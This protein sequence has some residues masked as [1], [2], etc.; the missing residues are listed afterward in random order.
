MS[1]RCAQRRFTGRGAAV[2]A[3]GAD[4][5]VDCDVVES[6]HQLMEAPDA[7]QSGF[8]GPRTG[9]VVAASSWA[10]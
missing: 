8:G 1:R 3:T 5:A 7:S 9:S 10:R 4:G 6:H 2:E